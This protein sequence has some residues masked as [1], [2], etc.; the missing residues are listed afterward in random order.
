MTYRNYL[1][2]I[3][4]KPTVSRNDVTDSAHFIT[5]PQLGTSSKQDKKK[6][7]SAAVLRRKFFVF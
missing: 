3:A 1:Y 5:Q 6:R 2:E 4:T 7:K